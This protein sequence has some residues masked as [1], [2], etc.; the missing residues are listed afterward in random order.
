MHTVHRFTKAHPVD[1]LHFNG[2]YRDGE[3]VP[4]AESDDAAQSSGVHALCGG[5][6]RLLQLRGESAMER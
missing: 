6:Y 2:Q 3:V 5:S 4:F 1:G